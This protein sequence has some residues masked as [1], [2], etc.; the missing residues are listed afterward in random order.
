MTY[1]FDYLTSHFFDKFLHHK[2]FFFLN[3]FSLQFKEKTE[4]QW[5]FWIKNL[6]QFP[7]DFNKGTSSDLEEKEWSV[8]CGRGQSISFRHLK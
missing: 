7:S 5:K 1:V 8:E 4:Q 6:T 2:F 3:H